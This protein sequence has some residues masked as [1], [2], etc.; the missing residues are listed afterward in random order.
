M[1][2]NILLYDLE[3]TRDRVEG[4]G[5]KYDFRV[6]K[7]VK[8]Q[9][10]MC[11]AYKWLGDPK[12]HFVSIN[13]A[14]G[15]EAM[16]EHLW[17]ILDDADIA[18]THN[19]NRFD[20]KMANRFFVK[21]KLGPVAPFKSIDTC[22]V[23]RSTFKF[24]SNSLNDIA[25]FFGLKGKESINY[26]DLEDDFMNNPSQRVERL[27]KKYNVR[28]VVLLEEIYLIMRPF[29]KNH[30]NLGDIEQVDGVCPKCSSSNLL[31]YGTAPRRNGRVQTYRCNDCGGRCSE[32]TIGKK[33][34]IVNG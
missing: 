23:A 2:K 29:I 6:V 19:G 15:A 1:S 33:G 24:Q 22:Q 12:T 3:V 7:T 28:D 18:I 30:P 9:E 4:Y 31:T 26:S 11:F 32:G 10:L 13:D 27:M 14:G 25:E 20:N 16:V 17:N 21:A 8:H 5:S 34:R